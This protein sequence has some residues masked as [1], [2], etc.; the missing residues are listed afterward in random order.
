MKLPAC[1]LA[2]RTTASWRKAPARE[3]SAED[4]ASPGAA[5]NLSGKGKP[6][7]LAPANP[8]TDRTMDL[9]NRALGHNRVVP[10]WIEL[11]QEVDEARRLLRG[12]IRAALALAQRGACPEDGWRG[13]LEERFGEEAAAVNRRV[14]EFNL[15]VP[16]NI[17]A[18]VFSASA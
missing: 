10:R 17:A 11:Q 9:F 15:E 14:D 3:G 5:D 2:P 18:I 8:F 6:L 7:N 12:R 4:G 1:R 16:P 13:V